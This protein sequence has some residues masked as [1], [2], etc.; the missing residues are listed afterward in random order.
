MLAGAAG[1]AEPPQRRTVS[2]RPSRATAVL[3]EDAISADVI[4]QRLRTIEIP[5]AVAVGDEVQVEVP[6]WRGDIRREIDVIEE[7]ARLD[8]GY[9]R[10]VG[11][12]PTLRGSGGMSASYG[13]RRRAKQLLCALGFHEMR[14]PSFASEA[15]LASMGDPTDRAIRVAN[16]LAADEGYLRTRLTPGLLH[17]LQRN[18]AR[19]VGSVRLFE[20]GVVFRSGDPVE[21]V[22]KIGFALMGPAEGSWHSPARTLDI[23]DATGVLEAFFD[24]L[25]VRGWSLGEPAPMP[26]HPGRSAA[27]LLDGIHAGTVGEI[28]PRICQE[29]DLADRAAIGVLSADHVERAASSEVT[30]QDVPRFPPVRRDLAFVVPSGVRADQVVGAIR[31]AAGGPIGEVVLFDVFA[32]APVP[33]GHV[34]LAYS[35]ELRADD[36]TMTDEESDEVVVR[37]AQ[38]LADRF[39]AELRGA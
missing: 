37:I 22:H 17:A 1:R 27:V 35:I 23:F 32:G 14:A 9:E 7:I 3:G 8:R 18:R 4:A 12:L 21:E 5:A 19:N 11:T 2:V 15:D 29:F 10:V 16:P 39:D 25:G 31:R 28:H 13:F 6:G 34:S 36:R 33:E 30:A 24:G 26:F 20:S 38:E